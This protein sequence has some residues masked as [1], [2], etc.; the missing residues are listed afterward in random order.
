MSKA[1]LPKLHD[2]HSQEI[3][4]LSEFGHILHDIH[5]LVSSFWS[6]SFQHVICLGNCVAHRLARR[7][8]CNSFLVWM[9][10]IPL[11]IL[12]SKTMI[13]V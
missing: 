3:N 6:V 9:E 2:I 4:V 10:S 1:S 12:V 13:L 8:F 7:S 11:N 5:S